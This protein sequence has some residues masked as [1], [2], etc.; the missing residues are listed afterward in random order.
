[1]DNETREAAIHKANAITDMI[2]YPDYILKEDG[3]DE[4]YHLLEVKPGEYF[5]NTIR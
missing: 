2:G 4:K 1:M 3:L 5:Q